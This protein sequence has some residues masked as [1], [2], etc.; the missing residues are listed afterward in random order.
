[1]D[2]RKIDQILGKASLIVFVI[3][4]LLGFITNNRSDKKM[5]RMIDDAVQKRLETK[6]EKKK[7]EENK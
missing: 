7:E 3:S 1:M 5:E 2:E 4:G 6:E